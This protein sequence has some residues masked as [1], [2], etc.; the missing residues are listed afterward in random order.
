VA[1]LVRKKRTFEGHLPVRLS[2]SITLIIF[3]AVPVV[4]AGVSVVYF[5][6]NAGQGFLGL[7][8]LCLEGYIQGS[9]LSAVLCT[10]VFVIS[11]MVVAANKGVRYKEKRDWIAFKIDQKKMNPYCLSRPFSMVDISEWADDGEAANAAA[12]SPFAPAEAL[13]SEVTDK[14]DAGAS[15]PATEGC[16]PSASRWLAVVVVVLWTVVV[17][18]FFHFN[19]TNSTMQSD[20]SWFD[21]IFLGLTLVLTVWVCSFA[22]HK[23]FPGIYGAPYVMILI[24]FVMVGV[25]LNISSAVR[26][27]SH[28]TT[29]EPIMSILPG[30]GVSSKMWQPPSRGSHGVPQ[31]YPVCNMVWGSK[32]SPLR[33]LDLAN[34]AWV[35]YDPTPDQTQAKA[36]IQKMLDGSFPTE[37]HAQLVDV[38]DYM[39]LPRWGHIHFPPTG[40]GTR[41][42][43][44][45][46]VKGTSTVMDALVDTNL[47]STVKVLQSFQLVLPVMTVLPRLVIQWILHRVHL[48]TAREAE[49]RIWDS[50]EKDVGDLMKKYP[51]DAFVITGHS[52][53]GGLSQIVAAK[54]NV[55]ALV[56]SA[57]GAEYSAKRFGIQVQSLKRNVVSVMPDH[58]VVPRVDLQGGMVQLIECRKKDGSEASALNCHSLVKTACEVWRT[59][60]DDRDFRKTCEPFVSRKDLGGL[61]DADDST[62]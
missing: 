40:N 58:D 37:R 42:T 55:P 33:A 14:P 9:L 25:S 50:L 57:P 16:T 56:W 39:D 48:S 31:P 2:D 28:E 8:T 41:G 13:Q 18:C 47:F 6:F 4:V 19:S 60:G 46:A 15:P 7:C 52:L 61:F 32:D 17:G 30:Q 53:G 54:L 5:G 22:L 1:A 49:K 26:P 44:V 59:C 3:E 24:F 12:T 34:L 51:N 36:H 23:T 43:R 10:V 20:A 29:M 11:D 35:I 21:P 45:V 38:K 27:E 62:A